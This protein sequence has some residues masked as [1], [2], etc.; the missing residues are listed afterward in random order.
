LQ[1]VTVAVVNMFLRC[2]VSVPHIKPKVRVAFALQTCT[3]FVVTGYWKFR[4]T[5]EDSIKM[6]LK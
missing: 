2:L 6:Y 5:F 4:R 1:Y 3:C